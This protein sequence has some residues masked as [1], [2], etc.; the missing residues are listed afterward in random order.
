MRARQE[1]LEIFSS[2]V[3]FE[4]DHFGSWLS[5]PRLRRHMQRCCESAEGAALKASPRSWSIYWHWQWQQSPQSMARDH[6]LAYVQEAGYWVAFKVAN[7]FHSAQYGVADCFQL[8]IAQL[9]K[10]LKGFNPDQG[11]DLN[12]YASTTF[13]SLIRDYLRQRKAVDIC[14]DWS[15][16]RKASQ[17]RLVDALQVQGMTIAEVEPYVLAWRAYRLIYVPSQSAGTRRMGVPDGAVW[18]AIAQQY[19]RDRHQLPDI[20][21]R[22]TA[23][24]T[25]QQIEA[26]MVTAAK[27]LRSYLYPASVSMNATRPGQAEGEFIDSF[28]DDDE[29]SPML[30][31]LAQEAQMQRQQQRSQ[32]DS[33]L[34]GAI[35]TADAESQQLLALYYGDTLT[36]TEIAEQMGIQQYAISRKLTRIKKALLLALAQWSQQSLHISPSPDLLNQ[37]SAALDAWLTARYSSSESA[38]LEQTSSKPA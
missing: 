3:Q 10:V 20:A 37:S 15:L 28:A 25:A 23:Q 11:F 6:L 24:Q 21:P 29:A 16:L 35:A 7:N 38:G 9:E 8:A 33:I 26:W 18:E 13:R 30:A 17:K 32:L 4:A 12:N 36:Q 1:L 14:T 19:N 5:D 27:A 34:T 2:F 31:M 22:A